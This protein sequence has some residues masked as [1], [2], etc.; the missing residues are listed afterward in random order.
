[1][2]DL[3]QMIIHYTAGEYRSGIPA[4][5]NKDFAVGTSGSNIAYQ[6]SKATPNAEQLDRKIQQALQQFRYT[7]DG[8]PLERG[9]D[10]SDSTEYVQRQLY[11]K[12]GTLQK[13]REVAFDT[14]AMFGLM[15]QE[16]A[17]AASKVR[18]KLCERT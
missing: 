17:K 2:S 12:D 11:M 14:A 9:T 3:K 15:E 8:K 5:G 1:M 10:R 16:T 13:C 6:I 18:P 4:I 7:Q